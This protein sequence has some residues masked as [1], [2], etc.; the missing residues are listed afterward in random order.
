MPQKVIVS[1][2]T[3]DKLRM[4]YISSSDVSIR[5]LQKKYG[6]PYNQIRNRCENENWLEQ[7]DE[8]KNQRA[9]KSIDLVSTHQ[10]NE[11]SKAFMLANKVMD[12]LGEVIEKIDPNDEYAMKNLKDATSAIKNLKEIGLFRSA[13]DQQE[14]E[15]RINKLRKDVEEEHG[16]TSI[17]VVIENG[18]DY[19]D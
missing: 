8:L 13:L 14:Q 17:T 1:E 6:I 11:C 10:A 19:T 16:D 2:D 18:D 3:W 12:K 4:E 9:Q 7:R 5:G 15:A